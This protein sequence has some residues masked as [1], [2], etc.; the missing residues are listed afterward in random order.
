MFTPIRQCVRVFFFISFFCLFFPQPRVSTSSL[1]VSSSFLPSLPTPPTILLPS[2]PPRYPSA[3]VKSSLLSAEPPHISL[4]FPHFSRYLRVSAFALYPIHLH[5]LCSSPDGTFSSFYMLLLHVSILQ[6]DLIFPRAIVCLSCVT[7][8]WLGF[9]LPC[10]LM[11][12]LL[13][14]YERRAHSHSSRETTSV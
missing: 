14:P 6:A 11:R 5:P 2:N 7:T 4:L 13:P 12:E 3:S 10:R 1:G 8:C 9:H